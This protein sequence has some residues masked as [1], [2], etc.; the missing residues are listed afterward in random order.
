MLTQEAPTR[1]IRMSVVK[2]KRASEVQCCLLSG[3]FVR[4]VSHFFERTFLCPETEECEACQVLPGRP[5]YYLPCWGAQSGL[6]GLLELS[7][8]SSMDLEQ[9]CKFAGLELSAGVQLLIRRTSE[10]RP[11]KIE[12]LGFRQEVPEMPLSEWVTAV[13]A[14]YGHPMMRVDESLEGYAARVHSAVVARANLGAECLRAAK[15]GGPNS[16]SR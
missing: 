12:V 10:R 11:P 5:Y 15:K 7:S 6:R 13:M 14:I 4:L 2:L 16:R 9:A 3:R 1:L 8:A